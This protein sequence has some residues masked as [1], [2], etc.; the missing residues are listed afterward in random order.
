MARLPSG[1][2]RRLILA[3]LALALL[4]GVMQ[5]W[6]RAPSLSAQRGDR[7]MAI[8][9]RD[10]VLPLDL[11]AAAEKR[12]ESLTIQ[13]GIHLENAYN[14]SIPDQT[15]MAD[16]WYWL[17]WPQA[18][19]DLME[20]RKIE[21]E[22]MVEFVNNIVGNDFTVEQEYV[23]P[24]L[25]SDGSR[26]QIFHFSG[27]F[28]VDDINLRDSPFN[29]LS[30]PLI[31]ETRPIDFAL[32]GPTP[33]LLRPD[34]DREGLLGAYAS[35]RGFQEQAVS[36]EPKRHRYTTNFGEIKP[37]HDYAQ[38]ALRVF[39]RTSPFASFVLWVLPLM[40]VMLIVFMAPSLEGSLGDLRIAIPSTAVLTLVVMQQTYQEELPPLPY[41]TFLDCLYLYSYF[42]S[43]GLFIL[44]L[45]G[46][47]LYA[48]SERSGASEASLAQVR[49]RVNRADV[50][51]Q[52]LAI[53]GLVLGA[54]LAWVRQ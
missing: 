26:H 10:I 41:L 47:N 52:V 9:R 43:I 4:V 44:F 17:T 27:I 50:W 29:V 51:F 19:A 36:L 22:N 12:P 31:L 54:A 37:H 18:V 32:D 49:Q 13:V 7:P 35:I 48:Q 5:P 33:V 34:P 39:Y 23:E 6:R 16:G 8:G 11:Q 21:P 1:L 38:V 53:G 2:P 28:Y 42:I 15:F 25:R 30:L 40:I 46:S 24:Q 3:V 20:A 14:L 45:W